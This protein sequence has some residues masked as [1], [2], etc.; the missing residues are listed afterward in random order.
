MCVFRGIPYPRPPVGELRFRPPESPEPWDGVLTPPGSA[1]AMPQDLRPVEDGLM[2]TSARPAGR[3]PEPQRLDAR[4]GGGGLPV[5]VW[6][7]GGSLKYRCRRGRA[8][9]RH[10]VRPRRRRH[11]HPNYRLHAAGYLYVPDGPARARSACWTRSPRWS[12]CGTSIAAFGGDPGRVT[13]AGES[14][15]GTASARCSARRPPRPVPPGDPASGA[16]SFDVPPE[17]AAVHGGGAAAARRRPRQRG[18]A[19]HDQRRALLAASEEAERDMLAL[20][21]ERGVRPGLMTSSAGPPRVDHLRG[22]RAAAKAADGGR[23]RPQPEW[24]C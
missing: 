19:R 6:I 10:D 22:R 23:G 11:R 21:A 4:A 12:G 7:H 17:V 18:G 15:G 1:A 16:S 8:L 2:N 20:L 14:A 3:L 13:V 24:T 5:L 9:R